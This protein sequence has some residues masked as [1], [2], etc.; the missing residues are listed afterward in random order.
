MRDR[1]A[2]GIEAVPRRRLDV[3]IRRFRGAVLVAN[4]TQAFELDDVAAFLL[5]KVDGVRSVEQLGELMAEK[6]GLS[7]I[8]ARTTTVELLDEMREHGVLEIVP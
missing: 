4:A 3:R 7:A 2:D 1:T 8:E 5:M 6:Y